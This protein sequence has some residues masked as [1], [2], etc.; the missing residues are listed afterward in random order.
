MAARV[1]GRVTDRPRRPLPVDGRVRAVWV[2]LTD[3]LLLKAAEFDQDV[4]ALMTCLM[5]V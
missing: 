1:P 2:A 3:L 5:R 4:W